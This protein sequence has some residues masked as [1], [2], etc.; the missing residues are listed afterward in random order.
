MLRIEE[1][2]IND[3]PII[4]ELFE[5]LIKEICLRTNSKPNLF[6]VSGTMEKCK[7]YLEYGIY[8]V[9]KAIVHKPNGYKYK[10]YFYDEETQLEYA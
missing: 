6:I 1:A 8:K 2:T 5:H 4:T 3:Y 7:Y 10:S 9:F